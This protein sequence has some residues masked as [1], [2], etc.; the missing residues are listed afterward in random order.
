MAVG[1]RERRAAVSV[2]ERTKRLFIAFGDPRDQSIV[3]RWLVPRLMLHGSDPVEPDIRARA[4]FVN[5]T[6]GAAVLDWA[7][8]IFGNG[9][10]IQLRLATQYSR[11]IAPATR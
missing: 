10:A 9:A 11:A 3:R 7:P 5:Y 1:E 8:G 4:P 2:V 6:R